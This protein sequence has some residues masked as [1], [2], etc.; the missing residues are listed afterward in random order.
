MNKETKKV[1]SQVWLAD[2]AYADFSGID[3]N[4]DSQ[5]RGKL[6]LSRSFGAT[7]ADQFVAAWK[8]RHFLNDT[9]SG[10]SATLF[11]SK[12]NPGQFSFALR[13]TQGFLGGKDLVVADLSDIVLDGLAMDQIVDMYN[14]WQRL[15][16]P[17]NT[18]Y[19]IARLDS[20]FAPA[21]Q[22]F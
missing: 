9:S 17:V 2:A 5:V 21:P 20:I 18:I 13:G 1:F 16:A 3:L 14:C 15:T 4:E 10:F 8:V 7:E 19:K 11:E 6:I 22:G 12:T